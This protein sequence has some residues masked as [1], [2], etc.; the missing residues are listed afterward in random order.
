MLIS[1]VSSTIVGKLHLSMIPSRP[2]EDVR[3]LVVHEGKYAF[4]LIDGAGGEVNGQLASAAIARKLDAILPAAMST[5]NNE[6]EAVAGLSD[7]LVAA[8]QAALDVKGM[9]TIVIFVVLPSGEWALTQVGDAVFL[10]LDAAG[11]WILPVM[12]KKFTLKRNMTWLLGG[13]ADVN[14]LS[15]EHVSGSLPFVA[16]VMTSDWSCGPSVNNILQDISFTVEIQGNYVQNQQ[17]LDWLKDRLIVQGRMMTTKELEDLLIA[18]QE[19]RVAEIAFSRDDM[20]LIFGV[21]KS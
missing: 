20:T 18:I 7:V 11:N 5:W 14:E 13:C 21:I 12:P 10:G 6:Q 2:N 9:A 19:G 16:F 3:G 15:P 4:Y 17:I 8:N 1:S